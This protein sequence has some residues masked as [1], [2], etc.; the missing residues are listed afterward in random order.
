[1]SFFTITTLFVVSVLIGL[2]YGKLLFH[3]VYQS[4]SRKSLEK[5][6]V[7]SKIVER[8]LNIK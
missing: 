7:E 3:D 5:A 8:F 1:M 4:E 6:I 2:V